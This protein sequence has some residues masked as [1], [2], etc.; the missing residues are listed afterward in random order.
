MCS[1][2]I[3]QVIQQRIQREGLPKLSRRGFLRAGGIAAAAAVA[4]P[5]V[6]TAAPRAQ[7]MMGDVVDLSHMLSPDFPVFPAFAP[8][9]VSNLVTVEENGFYAREWIFGE[10]T[11]TTHGR[12]RSLYCRWRTGARD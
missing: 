4:A 8:A 6:S 5:T 10:H 1:P 7:D 2:K 3:A 11:S 12:T 9:Q